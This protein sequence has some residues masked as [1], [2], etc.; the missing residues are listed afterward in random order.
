MA[1]R[2]PSQW[3]MRYQPCTETTRKTKKEL[4]QLLDNNPDLTEAIVEFCT[5]N[6]QDLSAELL[7][8]YLFETAVPALLE[9]VR[10]G[11]NDNDLTLKELLYENGLTKVCVA[12][13]YCWLEKLGFKYMNP[14][15]RPITLMGMNAQIQKSIEVSSSLGT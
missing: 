12:T 14:G 8:M 9:K 5:N 11:R 7:T 15:R 3:R 6:L 1:P 10:E 13:V 4:P 2:I